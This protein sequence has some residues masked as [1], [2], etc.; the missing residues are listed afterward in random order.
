MPFSVK[1]HI[2]WLEVSV[3]DPVLVKV[4]K[5]KH[6]LCREKTGCVLRETHLVTK[7]EKEF[8]SI[9]EITDEVEGLRSLKGVVKFDNKGVVNLLHDVSFNLCIVHLLCSN[10]KI[11]LKC[12]H[13]VNF[14]V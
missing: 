8:A 9:E 10:D 1:K 13:G 7:V 4:F 3:D 11:F 12:F 14:V 6:Y 2:L 5:G